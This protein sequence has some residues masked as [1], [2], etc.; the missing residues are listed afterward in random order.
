VLV[1]IT[2]AISPRMNQCELTFLKREPIDIAL[3][4]R[5]HQQYEAC[6]CDLGVTVISLPGEPDLPDAVFVEDPVVVLDEVAVLTRMGAGSR[7]P[8]AESL[9]TALAPFRRILRLHDPATLEGGDVMRVGRILY[10]GKS[11][12]TNAEGIRQLTNAI[13]PFG[14]T[15]KAV[16]VDGCMHLKT[17]CSYLGDN[18]LLVNREWVD[19]AAFPGFRI[20]DVAP[21]EAW[22][23]NV[24]KVGDMLLMPDAFPA[25]ADLLREQG[26]ALHTLDVSELMKAEAGLTC[27]SVLFDSAS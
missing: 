6:L 24:L 10:V 1:A 27:M 21:G 8:E 20:L 13:A 3:A 4:V 9:A 25:T 11:V 16:P 12:R 23:A 2:R 17:G 15:V 19:I 7:R 14:Y 26:F 22:A 5:E 18:T